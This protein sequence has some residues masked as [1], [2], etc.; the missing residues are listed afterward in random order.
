MLDW[1]DETISKVMLVTLDRQR[2]GMDPECIFLDSVLEDLMDQG[3]GTQSP[4]LLQHT[5]F[6]VV[7]DTCWSR[8]TVVRCNFRACNYF[9]NDG[10]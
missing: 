7:V 6:E 2:A 10:G 5:S 3:Q 1:E 4:S 8:T 9:T